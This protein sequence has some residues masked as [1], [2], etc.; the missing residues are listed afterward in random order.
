MAKILKGTDKDL[1][2]LFVTMLNEVKENVFAI[3]EQTGNHSREK[4]TITRS[5]WKLYN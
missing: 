3:N 5:K 1:N 2:L 4:E